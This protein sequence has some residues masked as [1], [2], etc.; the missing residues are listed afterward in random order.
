MVQRLRRGDVVFIPGRGAAMV[1]SVIGPDLAGGG[2]LP[3]AA[4]PD[5]LTS[6]QNRSPSRGLLPGLGAKR[7][8][9]LAVSGDVGKQ[10]LNPLDRTMNTDRRTYTSSDA[11]VLEV[12]RVDIVLLGKDAKGNI[13][14]KVNGLKI[15]R[16]FSKDALS[17]AIDIAAGDAPSDRADIETLEKWLNSSRL[18]DIARVILHTKGKDDEAL[19]R[20]GE[21]AVFMLASVRSVHNTDDKIRA[22]KE[23]ALFEGN[24]RFVFDPPLVIEMAK[25]TGIVLPAPQPVQEKRIK[26]PPVN[27]AVLANFEKRVSEVKGVVVTDKETSAFSLLEMFKQHVLS[28]QETDQALSVIFEGEA[29]AVNDPYNVVRKIKR[30]LEKKVKNGRPDIKEKVENVVRQINVWTQQSRRQP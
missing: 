29:S 16:H 28:E 27:S 3:P 5:F 26:V 12:A 22:N 23:A 4:G 6:A 30:K 7:P 21:S 24:L 8:D 19:F 25:E 20:L 18:D 15:A 1:G 17:K 13:S 10:K 2:L 14:F 9:T 11:G